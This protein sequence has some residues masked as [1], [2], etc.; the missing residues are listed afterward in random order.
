MSSERRA[1]W[2]F[3]TASRPWAESYQFIS[4]FRYHWDV[5]KISVFQKKLRIWKPRD[6]ITFTEFFFFK[7][8]K[9]WRERGKER[10]KKR[11]EV[12]KIKKKTNL[13]AIH[14]N[15]NILKRLFSPKS[16]ACW[17]ASWGRPMQVRSNQ[18]DQGGGGGGKGRRAARQGPI[19]F[20]LS[21][22]ARAESKAS[23]QFSDRAQRLCSTP[24]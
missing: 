24:V 6:A 7:E 16:S 3:Y 19:G 5:E 10:G 11:C 1:F 23:N 14:A 20:C 21:W 2:A 9:E 15:P 13:S 4:W 18:D 8:R 12:A 17:K 22:L